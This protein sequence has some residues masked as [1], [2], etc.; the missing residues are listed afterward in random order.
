MRFL[1]FG[2]Q[3]STLS[4]VTGLIYFRI[5]FI[6]ERREKL[7]VRK[8]KKKINGFECWAAKN[9]KKLKYMWLRCAC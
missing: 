1:C 7:V 9:V 4:R 6:L 2:T 8:K 3:K 5:F